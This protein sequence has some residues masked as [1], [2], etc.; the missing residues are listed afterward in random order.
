MVWYGAVWCGTVYG[1][2]WCGSV[3][4]EHEQQGCG[5][6]SLNFEPESKNQRPSTKQST[7]KEARE[8]NVFL[9]T[10]IVSLLSGAMN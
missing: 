1:V 9:C 6:I 4:C 10:Y 2:V 3:V 7:V 5:E 8:R